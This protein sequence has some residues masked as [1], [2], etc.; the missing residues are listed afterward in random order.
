MPRARDR[1]PVDSAIVVE[2]RSAPCS[3]NP[4]SRPLRSPTLRLRMKQRREGVAMKLCNPVQNLIGA[5]QD[6]IEWQLEGVPTSLP[7]S[8]LGP[9]PGGCTRT[10]RPMLDECQVVMFSQCWEARE[11]DFAELAWGHYVEG[12][13]VV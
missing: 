13:T 1:P 12:E 11:L 8:L 9:E 3:T 7:G 4:H 2:T 6:A 5:L 10:R